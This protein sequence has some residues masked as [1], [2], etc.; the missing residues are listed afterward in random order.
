[1]VDITAWLESSDSCER[2]PRRPPGPRFERSSFV[3]DLVRFS[4]L[5]RF[6][7]KLV[8]REPALAA[9]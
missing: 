5:E 9:G 4:G 6:E 1:M 7:K 8:K 3:T 2:E